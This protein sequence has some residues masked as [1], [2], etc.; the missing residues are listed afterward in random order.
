MGAYLL[1][2]LLYAWQIPHFYALAH[3]L[4]HDYAAAGHKM[5]SC[6]DPERA[7][8]WSYRYTAGMMA[9]APLSPVLGLTTWDFAL[10]GTIVTLPLLYQARR[11][12][13][14]PDAVTSRR[15][16]FGT[17]Y[18]LPIFAGLMVLEKL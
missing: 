6:S 17:I 9:I 8:L 10:D 7:A 16:F 15:L 12:M 18:W 2:T 5:L 11:F 13:D 14:N 3:N 1:G 4:R